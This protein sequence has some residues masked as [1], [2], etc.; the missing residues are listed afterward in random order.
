M[1][2]EK[3]SQLTNGNP[4]QTTD[5]I[6]IARD[7][8]NFSVTA[9]SVAALGGGGGGTISGGGTAGYVPLWTG[10]FTLA[11]SAL[12]DNGTTLSY[13]GS[14]FSFNAGGTITAGTPGASI[15]VRA[16]TNN[17]GN[18]GYSYILGGN[19]GSATGASVQTFGATSAGAGGDLDLFAG[20]ASGAH[21]GGNVVLGP[22][23]NISGNPVAAGV[24]YV[25]TRSSLTGLVT[26]LGNVTE[27]VVP[28]PPTAN[29]DSSSTK[30]ALIFCTD[31]KGPQDGATWGSVVVGSG[32]G[33]LL[34][35]TGSAWIVIG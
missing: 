21:V 31:A 30:G 10:T 16:P 9:A 19:S 8:S 5:L 26:Y 18:A 33:A 35:Y 32:T 1:P 23:P 22:G 14:N 4:A 7:G 13:G 3:I 17:T 2:S 15:V 27:G 24:I 29:P 25:A 28:S 34:R 6:P 20:T 12:Q 11:N